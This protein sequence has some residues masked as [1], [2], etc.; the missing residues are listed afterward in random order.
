MKVA[1]V[2][3]TL[4][5]NTRK[6]AEAVHAAMPP[7]AELFDVQQAPDPGAYD[8]VA[9]GFWVDRGTA[10]ARAA[11]YM[12]RIQG[13]KVFSF[14]TLGAEPA[15]EH[16]Q[17]CEAAAAG[18]YG[19]GCEIIGTY[20]C[21]GA[22]D[23]QLIEKMKQLPPGHPHAPSEKSRQRWAEAAQHPDAADLEGAA[24]AVRKALGQ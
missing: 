11:A 6:V 10:D 7:G 17:K 16:A 5:G 23:P 20:R 4:T 3:S 24:A 22:I 18:L 12:G 13:K 14:F 2:Y 8:V 19:A 1:V 15:S 9:M 21:R